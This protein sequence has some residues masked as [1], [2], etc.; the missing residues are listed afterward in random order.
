MAANVDLQVMIS[1]A[2]EMASRYSNDLHRAATKQEK[3][4]EEDKIEHEDE[5]KKV[6]EKDNVES[7]Q[8]MVELY[9]D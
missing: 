6:N 8:S 3:V 2:A 9:Y 5:V 1:R 7:A 4:A